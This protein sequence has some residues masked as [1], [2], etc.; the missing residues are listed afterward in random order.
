MKDLNNGN[1][2]V[3]TLPALAALGER[4]GYGGPWSSP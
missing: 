3:E 4:V 1:A 2:Y